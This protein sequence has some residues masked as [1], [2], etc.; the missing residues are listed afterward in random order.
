MRKFGISFESLAVICKEVSDVEE[1]MKKYGQDYV[2]EYKLFMERNKAIDSINERNTLLYNRAKEEYDEIEDKDSVLA[3]RA[4]NRMSRYKKWLDWTDEEKLEKIKEI[5]SVDIIED[6]NGNLLSNYNTSPRWVEYEIGGIYANILPIKEEKKDKYKEE[7]KDEDGVTIAKVGDVD[8][9]R[10]GDECSKQALGDIWD[11]F[12]ERKKDVTSQAI[13]EQYKDR[14]DFIKENS[15]FSTD[16]ILLPDGTW[17][18]NKINFY[19]IRFYN[20]E[21]RKKFANQYFD[22]FNIEKYK[23]YYIVIIQ[24]EPAQIAEY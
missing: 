1:L 5:Y 9:F 20:E 11:N 8:F 22:I 24:F 3:E 2:G 19:S 10:E 17:Y 4:K 21:E 13:I 15:K 6:E 7:L 14:D 23:D 16:A 12:Y 18:D